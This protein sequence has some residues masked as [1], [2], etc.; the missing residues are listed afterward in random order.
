MVATTTGGSAVESVRERGYWGEVWHDLRHD[1]SACLGL[2]L[3]GLLLCAAAFAPLIAPTDPNFQNVAGFASTGGPASP[4]RAFPLGTDSYGRDE[5]SRVLYGARVSLT[6]GI[7]ANVVSA[8]LALLVGGAAGM[9][10]GRLQSL[11]MRGVDV[12][13]SIPTLLLAI[14]LL[15]VTRPN[16]AT[17]ILIIGVTFAAYLSRV[18]FSQVVSLRQRDFVLAARASGVTSTRIFVRHIFPH[19]APSVIVVA[20]LGVA[21]AIQIEAALSYVGIGVQPPDAS[22]G[23]MISDGQAYIGAA[24]WL[25]LAPGVAIVATMVGF[26]LLGDA[27]RDA[28]DPTLERRFRVI[29]SPGIR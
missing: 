15:A 11:I 3:V 10:G 14:T 29:G 28:F 18:V 27:L 5:L 16:L 1:W 12:V 22:W 17:L 7:L 19:V 25:I 26:A 20:T 9:A 23:N 8:T 21:N 13:L 4:S 24:P 6:V 2:V